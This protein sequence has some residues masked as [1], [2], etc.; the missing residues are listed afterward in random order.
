M[1][2]SE[3]TRLNIYVVFHVNKVYSGQYSD[4]TGVLYSP[5]F[6]N[7]YPDRADSFYYITVASGYVVNLVV[8]ELETEACCDYVKVSNFHLSV[9]V[10]N[11]PGMVLLRWRDVYSMLLCIILTFIIYLTQ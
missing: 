4:L 1:V 5:S 7:D 2:L 3:Y 10:L 9:C 8:T 11:T 6:P